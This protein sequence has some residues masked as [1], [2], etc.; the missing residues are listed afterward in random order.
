MSKTVHTQKNSILIPVSFMALPEE[1]KRWEEA[2]KRVD[3]TR[4]WWIRNRLLA[5]DS[6]DEEKNLAARKELVALEKAR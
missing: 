6:Q 2:A 3:R 5:M 4:S 1:I